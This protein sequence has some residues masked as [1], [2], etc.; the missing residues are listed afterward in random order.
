MVINVIKK[1]GHT[2]IFG[3]LAAFYLYAIKGRKSLLEAQDAFF[4]LSLFLTLL[5][6]ISDEYHQSFDPGRHSSEKDVCIDFCGALTVLVI[7][8][9]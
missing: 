6:S 5:Y 2:V 7:L 4:V 1:S 3:V 8:Y 9:C